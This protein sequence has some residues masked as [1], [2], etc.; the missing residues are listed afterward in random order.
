MLLIIC[1][2]R[3]FHLFLGWFS[4]LAKP[5]FLQNLVETKSHDNRANGVMD[6]SWVFY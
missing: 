3:K 6:T 1:L 4:L 2:H 5:L